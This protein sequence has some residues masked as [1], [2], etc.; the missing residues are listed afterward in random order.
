[1]VKS[2]INH[3]Y[4]D[5][6]FPQDEDLILYDDEEITDNTEGEGEACWKVL[7]VDDDH[8]VH[9]VT[10]LALRRFT[11]QQQS[12]KF[13][14][15]YSTV[16]AMNL[17][18]A[19]PNIAV[20]LLDIVMEEKD[21]GLKLAQWMRDDLDNKF[22]RIILRT[23]Q[24][25]E[26]PEES[27]ILNYAINDYK[28]KSE[29]TRQKLF[30]TLTTALRSYCDLIAIE[31]QRQE[32]QQLYADLGESHQQLQV[33]KEKEAQANRVKTDFL[34]I[35]NHELRTPLNAIIGLSDVLSEEVYGALNE[36]Q[37]RTVSTLKQ[38]AYHLLNLIK[39]ILDFVNIEAEMLQLKPERVNAAKICREAA[40]LVKQS[41]DKKNIQIALDVDD[42][43]TIT[44]D[45]VR[46][47]HIMINLLDNAVKFTPSGGQIGIKMT[48]SVQ[49][50]KVNFTVWDTGIGFDMSDVDALLKPFVQADSS[51]TRYYEGIGIGLT[52]VDRLV[53]MHQGEIVIRS[54][55]G[56]GSQFAIVLPLQP[57]ESV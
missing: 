47:K 35:M 15:A 28:T 53:K 6:L 2:K 50:Q 20:I 56:R 19:Y 4:N 46:L 23:G 5:E 17:M 8:E 11:F 1:M 57:N 38:S 21:S 45:P 52:L 37:S 14:S 36:G 29:L 33:A 48:A 51:N 41:A 16:E 30:T 3:L 18:K 27:V 55:K 40:Q 39:E 24:P 12:I 42:L 13:I 9:D 49:E 32:L 7:I 44:A 31:N 54:E 22:V 43:I 34:R 25:G 10:K 26:A